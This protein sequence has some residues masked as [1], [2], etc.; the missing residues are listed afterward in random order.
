MTG[1]DQSASEVRPSD[2]TLWRVVW[3]NVVIHVIGLALA[4]F[5]IRPGSPLTP[6]NER[7]AYLATWPE[8]WYLGWM[9]W[10]L[11]AVALVCVMWA[12]SGRLL[13]DAKKSVEGGGSQGPPDKRT[14]LALRALVIVAAVFDL[15]CDAIYIV[16][17]PVLAFEAQAASLRPEKLERFLFW[18]RTVNAVSLTAGNGVYTIAIGLLALALHRAGKA[19][20]A[21]SALAAGVVVFGLALAAAGPLELPVLVL[22]TT[23]PTIG[24]FC[25]W[26]I[27]AARDVTRAGRHGMLAATER[28]KP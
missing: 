9:S 3:S 11:C 28:E 21:A 23:S 12:F 22:A 24:L 8:A 1:P 16:V 7:I 26:S 27:L 15:T 5:G 4:A 13:A 20:K 2:R 18:E 10:V 6:V 19:S 14:A 17:F 25:A